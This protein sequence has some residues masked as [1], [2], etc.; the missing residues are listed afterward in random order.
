M[1]ED[2]EF[3]LIEFAALLFW[4]LYRQTYGQWWVVGTDDLCVIESSMESVIE[5][6]G[7][8]SYS[9][10]PPAWACGQVLG[11]AYILVIKVVKYW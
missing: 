7:F 10:F 5:E 8:G 3:H 11:S 6:D 9:R 2:M 4:R 1:F